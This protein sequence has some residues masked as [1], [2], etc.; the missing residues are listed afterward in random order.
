MEC[1]TLSPRRPLKWGHLSNRDIFS[2]PKN[3]LLQPLNGHLLC[4]HWCHIRG[5]P[6]YKLPIIDI[7]LYLSSS[8]NCKHSGLSTHAAYFGT[9]VEIEFRDLS[10]THGEST[11][12]HNYKVTGGSWKRG[13]PTPTLMPKG[14]ASNRKPQRQSV[15]QNHG[16]LTPNEEFARCLIGQLSLGEWVGSSQHVSRCV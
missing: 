4:S 12:P 10:H 14:T 5:V 13:R 1:R 7:I 8:T 15:N 2:F 16:L 11:V 3:S 9:C 6:L